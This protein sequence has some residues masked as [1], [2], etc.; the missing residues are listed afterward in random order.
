VRVNQSGN[1]GELWNGDG[2]EVM[3]SRG[4]RSNATPGPHDYHVL[5]NPDGEVTD[6]RGTGGG[7]DRSWSAHASVAVRRAAQGYDVE[8]AIPW[9][10]LEGAPAAGDQLGLDVANNDSD[11]AGQLTPFDWAAL[12]HFGEPSGWGTMVMATNS[13]ARLPTASP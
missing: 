7:W 3:L 9:S 1:D 5:V 4:D 11:R 8:L 6:E 10:A 12:T 2:I 13:C